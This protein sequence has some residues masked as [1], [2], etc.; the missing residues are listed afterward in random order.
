MGKT[1]LCRI[2][3]NTY[4]ESGYDYLGTESFQ[5]LS[6]DHFGVMWS[7]QVANLGKFGY[8]QSGSCGSRI[9]FNSDPKGFKSIRIT[10]PK[11]SS[12]CEFGKVFQMPIPTPILLYSCNR[13]CS[14][15]NNV[16][17]QY[18]L[19]EP[20]AVF[21]VYSSRRSF[22]VRKFSCLTAHNLPDHNFKS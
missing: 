2:F 10:N 11:D 19:I 5:V 7:V 21:N 8:F 18:K 13:L 6:P 15:R 9:F 16:A 14:T 12:P 1:K 22:S 20:F 17:L 4:S 3:W